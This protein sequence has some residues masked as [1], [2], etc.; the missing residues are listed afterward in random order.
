M[1]AGKQKRLAKQAFF[2][3]EGKALK[4]LVYYLF[5]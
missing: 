3:F 5:G 2:V 1:K 4:P